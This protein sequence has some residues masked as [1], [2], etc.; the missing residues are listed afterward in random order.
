MNRFRK[1]WFPL[2]HKYYSWELNKQYIQKKENYYWFWL[3]VQ[4]KRNYL[5]YWVQAQQL[6]L[7][8]WKTNNWFCMRNPPNPKKNTK[9][10]IHIDLSSQ[11]LNPQ[12]THSD[13]PPHSPKSTS[14]P[15]HPIENCPHKGTNPKSPPVSITLPEELSPSQ[16]MAQS[17]ESF[18]QT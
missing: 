5:Y 14:V 3:M 6:I 11:E 7:I 17:K 10:R 8:H 2:G 12:H 9:K 15:P 1:C 13:C 16:S 4:H 18:N